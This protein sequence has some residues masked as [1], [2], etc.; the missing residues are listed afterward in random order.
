MAIST[1]KPTNARNVFRVE[2]KRVIATSV[3]SLQELNPSVGAKV[4][5]E[6]LSPRRKIAL[7]LLGFIEG[8]SI[9]V[10]A[11]RKSAGYSAKSLEGVML[12]VHIMMQGR[13]CTFMSRL[14]KV[15]PEP[16][17]Y[18]HLAYP[19]SFDVSNIRKNTRVALQLPVSIEFQDQQR[20]QNFEIPNMVYCTDVSLQ[21]L[22]IEA[23]QVL[24][25]L[26]D[27]YFVTM[28]LKIAGVDQLLLTSLILRSVKTSAAGIVLHGL[29]FQDNEDE[30]KVLIAAYV[31]KEILVKLGYVDK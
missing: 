11:P 30:A 3:Q 2:R 14:M 19:V 22:G 9:L 27:Q 1:G 13:I 24:G 16:Y 29:E 15:M 31:Y 10:S 6:M 17:G 23:P 26:G 12:K 28:R 21:G 18:W 5:I 25:E 4:V 8:K 7:E 20:G